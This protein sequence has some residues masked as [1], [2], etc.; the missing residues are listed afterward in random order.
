MT[1]HHPGLSGILDKL[2]FSRKENR[3]QGTPCHSGHLIDI[4]AAMA[5]KSMGCAHGIIL[6]PLEAIPMDQTAGQEQNDV[7]EVTPLPAAAPSALGREGL[8]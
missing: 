2:S 3:S 7:L 6:V 5:R 1:K 8:L 4:S